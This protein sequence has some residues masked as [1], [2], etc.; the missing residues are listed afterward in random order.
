MKLY[1][2]LRFQNRFINVLKWKGVLPSFFLIACFSF[3]SFSQVIRPGRGKP[4]YGRF[5][6]TASQKPFLFHKRNMLTLNLFDL[7]FTNL[8]FNYEF[9]SK[10][11][12][13]G[14]GLAL[15]FNAGGRPD[16]TGYSPFNLGSFTYERNRNFETD[17]SYN[18]Y[19]A[20]QKRVSPY[21]GVDLRSGFF[22]YYTY[23]YIGNQNTGNYIFL[24]NKY[25][26]SYLNGNI[27]AGILFNPNEVLTFYMKGYMGLRR[28]N[29]VFPDYT[30]PFFS[31]ELGI[32]FKF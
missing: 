14:Y 22:N 27:H 18:Y 20:G 31:F 24:S 26:G 12:H 21:V 32:G 13:F 30:Y 11:G 6:D 16:T 28:F 17:I 10:S 29:T 15:S 1:P 4:V 9:F 23:S 25:T 2:L 7:M 3:P 8:T 19:P 5:E